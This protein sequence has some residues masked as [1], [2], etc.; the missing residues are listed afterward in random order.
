MRNTYAVVANMTDMTKPSQEFSRFVR[1]FYVER[2]PH[3]EEPG[4][5][6]AAALRRFD[7]AAT[8]AQTVPGRL[9]EAEC[10]RCRT[11]V[12]VERSWE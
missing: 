9:V 4:D 3:V 2:P 7:V 8:G 5:W 11:A 6:I 12:P 1:A 10:E